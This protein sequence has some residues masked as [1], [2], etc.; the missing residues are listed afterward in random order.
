MSDQ[1]TVQDLH[2]GSQAKMASLGKE[3]QSGCRDYYFQP[4]DEVELVCGFTGSD[5]MFA[6][7]TGNGIQMY[8]CSG[9]CGMFKGPKPE[10]HQG[11]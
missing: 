8:C 10:T 1:H 2:E 4:L 9:L 6:T 11:L 7:D 5:G 3:L